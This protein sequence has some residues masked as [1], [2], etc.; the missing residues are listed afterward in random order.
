MAHVEEFVGDKYT[1][2]YL[3]AD[4]SGRLV[5][6]AVIFAILETVFFGLYLVARF[7]SR[8]L[9]SLDVY[10]MVL[11]YPFC[12]SLTVMALRKSHISQDPVVAVMAE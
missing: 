9:K 4:H 8:S 10:F 5:N 12:F 7:R 2:E 6:I 11:A 3:S 1:P